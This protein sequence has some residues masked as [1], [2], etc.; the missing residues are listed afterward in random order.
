MQRGTGVIGLGTVAWAAST[1][2]NVSVTVASVS[3]PSRNVVETTG[4]TPDAGG[5]S[6]RQRPIDE[7]EVYV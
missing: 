1:V 4:E 7:G 5:T 3:T 6:P 2:G